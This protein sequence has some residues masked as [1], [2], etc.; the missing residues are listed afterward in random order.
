[1]LVA[2]ACALGSACT[3]LTGIGDLDVASETSAP[4]DRSV[5]EQAPTPRD[6]AGIVLDTD[7]DAEAAAPR[8]APDEFCDDFDDGGL[9]ARWTTIVEEGGTVSLDTTRS[10]SAPRSLNVVTPSGIDDVFRRAYLFR[11]VAQPS[12][13]RCTFMMRVNAA[14]ATSVRFIDFFFFRASG[15]QIPRYEL[16]W[17]T[18]GTASAIRE[19]VFFSDGGCGCPRKEQIMPSLPVGQWIRVTLELSFSSA[20][21]SYDG[22][23]VYSSSFAGF[24]PA[25][26]GIA[27]GTDHKD[28]IATNVSFDDLVC[29]TSP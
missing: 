2:C 18:R 24:T 8:C 19:D 3:L 23:V 7:A 12:P 11:T 15:P 28:A 6:A 14:Y 27:I 22:G 1:M 25:T 16:R 10:V 9:G 5:D 17:G 21:V 26:L 4:P 20:T 13:I 29:D